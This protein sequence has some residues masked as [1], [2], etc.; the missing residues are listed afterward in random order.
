MMSRFTIRQR[1]LIFGAVWLGFCGV[2]LT[3]YLVSQAKLALLQSAVKQS[4]VIANR[5]GE[6][7]S[8]HLYAGNSDAIDDL[9][10]SILKHP[11][12]IGAYI[13]GDIRSEIQ[14]P[15]VE[16][17]DLSRELSVGNSR[18]VRVDGK[19]A[20]QSIAPIL[21]PSTGDV[22]SD[23]DIF[24]KR[25]NPQEQGRAVLLLSV[26]PIF[27]QLATLVSRVSIFLGALLV[28]GV[29]IG[30][31]LSGAMISPLRQLARDASVVKQTEISEVKSGSR[32]PSDEIDIIWESFK[33]LRG[34]VNQKTRE[35]D[36][37]QNDIEHESQKTVDLEQMNDRLVNIMRQKNDLILQL[38]HEVKAPIATLKALVKNLKDGVVSE[39]RQ[40]RCLDRINEITNQ[41]KGLME[42]IL[43]FALGE[44]GRIRLEIR[45]ES[46][47]SVVERSVMA[48]QE[49]QQER[50][51]KCV[52][53]RSVK[54][55]SILADVNLIG[56]VLF[57]LLHNALKASHPGSVVFIH[58]NEAIKEVIVNV[59]DSGKGIDA[60]RQ[61]K[62]LNDPQPP[63]DKG[64]GEVGLY[65]ARYLLELHGGRI[66]FESEKGK[67]TSFY[68]SLPNVPPSINA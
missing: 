19:R 24:G 64:G 35:L 20:I 43:E 65:I 39:E 2:L 14:A 46:L 62:L 53:T 30:W 22:L 63:N 16:V 50:H 42:R 8:V 61:A 47:Q 54:D 57:N 49:M 17:L 31:M 68:F 41:L 10:A 13:E 21:F 45:K 15:R 25:V 59:T 44:T 5:I 18:I 56:Q 40:P 6:E 11:E 34:S 48:L 3:W 12:V 4:Q 67:G 32:R 33:S 52:I 9:L 28:G 55:V 26:E 60:G 66:W 37:L 38:S 7:A 1:L 58:A 36:Q 29:G 23:K 51:V 27:D